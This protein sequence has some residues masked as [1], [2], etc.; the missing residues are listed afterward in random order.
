MLQ[1]QT[2][3]QEFEFEA[4]GQEGISPMVWIAGLA[5]VVIVVLIFWLRRKKK[6]DDISLLK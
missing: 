5:V 2:S 4:I 1:S 6:S 3:A